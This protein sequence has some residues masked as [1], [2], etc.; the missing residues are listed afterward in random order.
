[1]APLVHIV[2]ETQKGAMSGDQAADAAKTA[3]SLLG[4]ASTHVSRERWKKVILALNKKVHPLAEEEEVFAEAA[5]LLLGKVFEEKM[6]AHLESL[7]CLSSS[8]ERRQDFRQSRS[9]FPPRGSGRGSFRRGGGYRGNQQ[10]WFQ[11]YHKGKENCQTQRQ[12]R[13][14]NQ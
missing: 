7:Q 11:P 14:K 12:Q 8:R 13:N 9:Q 6:K 1:M 4:N 10:R 5:P 2:E 3:L